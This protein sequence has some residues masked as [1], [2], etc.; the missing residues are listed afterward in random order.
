MVVRRVGDLIRAAALDAGA[1]QLPSEDELR[2]AYATGRNV[3]RDALASLRVEGLIRRQPGTGTFVV[4]ERFRHR[5]DV[6]AG[7]APSTDQ[8]QTTRDVL[9]QAV[10]P[11]PPVVAE[12]LG[13]DS[14]ADCVM[15]EHVTLVNGEAAGFWT[16]YLHPRL[17]EVGRR[18]RPG[19]S[20]HEVIV[21]VS[22]LEVVEVRTSIAAALARS[23][24]ADSLA[25]ADG[26]P[27]IRQ[28][29]VTVLAD[30]QVCEFALGWARADRTILW[31]VR[32][33]SSP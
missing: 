20:L 12:A 7:F 16:S 30:G 9:D 26:D 13:L 19:D 31:T 1:A 24:V 15:V 21:A 3:V 5:V 2:R 11:A 28:Q 32:R 25:L 4:G 22:G 14:G 18:I 17:A 8:V 10:I 27:V 23:S 29:R 6:L 33:A